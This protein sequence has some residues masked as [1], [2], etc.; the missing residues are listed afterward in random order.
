[1]QREKSIIVD[2]I[3]VGKLP[4]INIVYLVQLY[5]FLSKL[6]SALYSENQNM[7]VEACLLPVR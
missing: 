1:M 6:E 7:Y 2:F 5:T 4:S 3:K